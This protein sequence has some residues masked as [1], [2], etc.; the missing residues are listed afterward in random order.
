MRL[1]V[2]VILLAVLMIVSAQSLIAQSKDLLVSVTFKTNNP[3]GNSPPM[4]GPEPA[5]TDANPLFSTANVWNNL[6]LAYSQTTDPSWT[7]LVD[8]T[9]ADSG[10]TLSITGTVIAIDLTPWIPNPD[11]LRS[12]FMAWNS[13]T[14]GG[15]AFGPGE[16]TSITWTLTGLPVSTTFDI[17]VY[18]SV[19]DL[20][21]SFDMTIQNTTMS[22]PT[23]NSANSPQPNCVLFTNVMSDNHGTISGVASGVGESLDAVNEANWSG[24]QLVKVANGKGRKLG[25]HR[26]PKH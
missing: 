20:D 5:A 2:S 8:S 13:W 3:F 9:G 22:V 11:P 16:S 1:L 17:C 15:G 26:S 7:N 4:S 18:G 23:F 21:R 14:N 25:F 24:F 19:A 10:I 12:A 6:P